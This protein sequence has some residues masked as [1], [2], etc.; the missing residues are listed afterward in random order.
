MDSSCV[1]DLS[2]GLPDSALR[3]YQEGRPVA[4]K[5]TTKPIL[6]IRVERGS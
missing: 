4:N 2:P 3:M 6:R 1:V 5:F